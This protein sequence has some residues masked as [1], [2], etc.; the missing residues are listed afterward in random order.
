MFETVPMRLW[1]AKVI[2]V[3]LLAGAIGL[4]VRQ[5][6]L[7]R[8]RQEN[9]TLGEQ[10]REA[11]RLARENAAFQAPEIDWAELER[12]RSLRGEMP[13]LR[14]QAVRIRDA[15]RV[16]PDALEEE[17][18]SLL[19]RLREEQERAALLRAWRDAADA[20]KAIGRELSDA[21][22]MILNVARYND[23]VI[24]GSFPELDAAVKTLVAKDAP[25]TRPFLE[26]LHSLLESDDPPGRITKQFEFIRNRN[27]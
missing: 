18:A 13:R 11:D 24:A 5:P 9:A 16:D 2:L 7:E 10:A 25:Q 26:H 15:A 6:E 27:R 21:L 17:L 23:G 14:G 1:L 8:L 19:P 4:A 12:L 20:D 22:D 3:V